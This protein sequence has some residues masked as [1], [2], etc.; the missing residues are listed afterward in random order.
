MKIVFLTSKSLR[1]ALFLKEMKVNNIPL[2]AILIE[3]Q[4]LKPCERVKKAITQLGLAKTI[5]IALKRGLGI[6]VPRIV[7]DWIRT[8]FYLAYADTVYVVDNFNGMKCEKILQKIQPD[9]IVLGNS[10]IIRKNILNI[11]KIG[12]INAHPGLLPRYRGLHTLQWAI[13][14]GDNIG[15]TVHFINE[16]VDTGGIIKQDVVNIEAND[17]IASLND[18]VRVLCAKLMAETVL[19]FVDGEYI[20]VIPQSIENGQQYYKMQKK[21][22]GETEKKLQI[23][24]GRLKI[25]REY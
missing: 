24:T 2:E 8:S 6:I 3:D 22:L 14:Y 20:Q 13:Y 11:P 21:L 15:A 19:K 17:T 16:G 18:K 7:E 10:R 12:I 9:L 25:L 4:D 23:I 1:G 5:K